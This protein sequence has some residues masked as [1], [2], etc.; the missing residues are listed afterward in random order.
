MKLCLFFNIPSLYRQLIYTKIDKEYDCDW[1][2][3]D[4]QSNIKQFDTSCLNNPVSIFHVKKV[5]KGI[6][7]VKGLTKLIVNKR[8]NTFLMIGD[9]HDIATWFFLFKKCLFYRKKKVYFWTHGWYGKETKLEKILKKAFFKM[10]DGIFLYG[11]YAKKLMIKEGF[12]PDKL[13]VIHNSLN[14]DKQLAIRKALKPEPIYKEHF[15]NN[16]Q[17]IIFI[18]R[19]TNVKKLDMALHALA[20]CKAR[21]YNYNLTFIGDGEAKEKLVSLTKDLQLTDQ[22]WFYGACYDENINA[23]MIYN[24]DLCISPGNVGLTAMHS[25]VFGTPVITHNDFPHQMPEFEAIKDGLTGAFYIAGDIKDL[26]LCIS[27]WLNVHTG[28]RTEIRQACYNEI[29]HYW[30]PQFQLKVINNSIYI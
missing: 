4:L 3:T 30:K 21:G 7:Y 10:T 26:A 5:K 11:N 13:F 9:S 15:K 14:Y 6:F 16:N 1:Y 27:N 20:I 8:Y 12:N 23:K 18:G 19:L 17:N 24:A 2:F 22:V 29:D 25:M 28:K